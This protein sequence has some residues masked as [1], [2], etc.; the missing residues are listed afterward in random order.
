MKNYSD[1][2]TE[3]YEIISCLTEEEFNKIPN[4]L[5]NV[6]KENRNL[7]YE[8][9]IY[10]DIELKD[11]KMLPETKAILF[12]I[13]RDYLCTPIQ[14]EKIIR[15]QAEERRKNEELKRKYY[16]ASRRSI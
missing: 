15:M 6:I 8:Y 14:K 2:F 13:F 16:Y 11:H 1:A 9:E 3:V 10:D 7:G 12:N 5:I 4:D